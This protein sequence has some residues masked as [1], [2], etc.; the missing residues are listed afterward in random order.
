MEPSSWL[1]SDHEMDYVALQSVDFTCTVLLKDL[2]DR[3]ASKHFDVLLVGHIH[4]QIMVFVFCRHPQLSQPRL[5]AFVD[6]GWGRRP[7]Q[8]L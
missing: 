4:Q 7:L 2:S 5:H 6:N 1:I 3:W 8:L